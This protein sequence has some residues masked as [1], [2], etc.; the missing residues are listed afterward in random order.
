[1]AGLYT[2][3]KQLQRATIKGDAPGE[4]GRPS[5]QLLWPWQGCCSIVTVYT[6]ACNSVGGKGRINHH[7]SC[8]YKVELNR[9]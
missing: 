8:I 5:N 9:L 3:L 7:Q 4:G 2:C 1:M 6:S